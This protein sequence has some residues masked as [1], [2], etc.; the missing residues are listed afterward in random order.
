LH[1]TLIF[2]KK[3]IVS[4]MESINSSKKRV[5]KG[6]PK[7]HVRKATKSKHRKIIEARLNQWHNSPFKKIQ[8][9][10]FFYR[11]KNGES[12]ILLRQHHP[13]NTSSSKKAFGD[14]IIFNSS[15]VNKLINHLRIMMM[16]QSGEKKLTDE[17]SNIIIDE[18]DIRSKQS[19][20]R[21]ITSELIV[22]KMEKIFSDV[23]YSNCMGCLEGIENQLGHELCLASI[24]EKVDICFPIMMD[25]INIDAFTSNN[26]EQ[27]LNDDEWIRLTKHSLLKLLSI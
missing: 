5:R 1:F 27:L 25:K 3:N 22:R 18:W 9:E 15:D 10:T 4:T 13:E 17:T 26:K 11:M 21:R 16:R 12:L 6:T 8:L 24:E 14:F 19:S 23:V 7:K 20:H 2:E